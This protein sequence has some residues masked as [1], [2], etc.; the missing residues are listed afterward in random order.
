MVVCVPLNGSACCPGP[1]IS[2]GIRPGCFDFGVLGPRAPVR[3]E[4]GDVV[5]IQIKHP[6]DGFNRWDQTL[7]LCEKRIAQRGEGHR[8]L[9]ANNAQLRVILQRTLGWAMRGVGFVVGS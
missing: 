8:T 1:K 9:K 5:F 7:R 4:P 6:A 3:N 2:R